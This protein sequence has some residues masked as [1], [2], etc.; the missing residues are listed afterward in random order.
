MIRVMFLNFS[1]KVPFFNK[2]GGGG[3]RRAGKTPLWLPCYISKKL[4][5]T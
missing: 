5:R 3:N 1:G 2:E 4:D